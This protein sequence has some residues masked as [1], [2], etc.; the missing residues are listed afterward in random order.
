M[1]LK[2]PSYPGC[3]VPSTKTGAVI[4]KLDVI[5]MVHGPFPGRLNRI[6]LS[7]EIVFEFVI[8]SRSEPAPWLF[9]LVT[10]KSANAEFN[11][12]L[13]AK[14]N[15]QRRGEFIVGIGYGYFRE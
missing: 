5:L 10:T 11:E 9:V 8:A 12:R 15:V 1:R 4:C 13:A 6:V 14:S 7:D 2:A 3:V